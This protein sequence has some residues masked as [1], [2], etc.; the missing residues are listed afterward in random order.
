[1][2]AVMTGLVLTSSS[3]SASFHETKIRELSGVTTT[4]AN[5]SY[6]EVQMYQPGQ[7]MLS[8]GAGL[9]TCNATCTVTHSF[10]SF[11]DVAHGENQ[12]TVL[13]GDTGLTSPAPDVTVDLNLDAIAAGGAACYTVLPSLAG[14]YRDCVSWGT[15]TGQA[16]LTADF[17]ASGAAGTP[18]AGPLPGGTTAGSSAL[19]RDIS[20]NCPTLLE[21]ADDHDDSATDFGLASRDPRPNSV[22]PTETSCAPPSAPDTKITAKPKDVIHTHTATY[23]FKAI[24]PDGATFEC[25]FDSKPFK[26]CDSPKE[27]KNLAK[28]THMFQVRASKAGRTDPHPAKDSFRVKP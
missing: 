15:F 10:G 17:G 23:K 21:A 16:V 4:G 26:A 5:D 27:Y 12:S 14:P 7:N 6:I 3:A 8:G 18:H 25:K 11:P 13:F 2:L 20:P 28:G 1:V 9:F 19:I 24:P 22:T